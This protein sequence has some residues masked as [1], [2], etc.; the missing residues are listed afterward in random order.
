M[1][2]PAGVGPGVYLAVTGPRRLRGLLAAATVQMN[3]SR[4]ARPQGARSWEQ[5]GEDISVR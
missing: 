1:R 2:G 5:D 4:V 3:L